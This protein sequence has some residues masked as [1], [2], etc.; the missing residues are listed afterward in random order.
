MDLLR[1]DE[2]LAHGLGVR[3][4]HQGPGRGVGEGPIGVLDA[5][6]GGEVLRVPH[7]TVADEEVVPG[8]G[9]Q[10]LGQLGGST[11]LRFDQPLQPA[12]GRPV[13]GGEHLTS[14]RVHDRDDRLGAEA[15]R[16]GEQVQRADA[17]HGDAQGERHRLGG[18]DA[19]AQPG[20]QPRTDPDGDGAELAVLHLRGS[21]HLFDHGGEQLGVALVPVDLGGGAHALMAAE[22][23]A[24]L[25]RGRLHT[26]DQHHAPPAAAGRA[27]HSAAKRGAHPG[28]T[29]CTRTARSSGSWPSSSAISR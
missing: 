7:G 29:I 10:F 20:E 8:V 19:D 1:S 22:R 23:A 27:R 9:A 6:A 28:P 18:G 24:D 5:L 12:G 13:G 26:E 2:L 4:L 3:Q 25:R 16:E 15:Q 11:D 14:P 17:D 21:A